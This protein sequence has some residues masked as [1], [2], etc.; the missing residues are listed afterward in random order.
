MAREVIVNQL[1]DA[2]RSLYEARYAATGPEGPVDGKHY[3]EMDRQTFDDIVQLQDKLQK[4]ILRLEKE[5]S[6]EQ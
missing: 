6:N 5:K 2:M 4:L 3:P 1:W